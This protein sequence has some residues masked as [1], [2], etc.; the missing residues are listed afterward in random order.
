VRPQLDIATHQLQEDNDVVPSDII[1]AV[2]VEGD[3]P[4]EATNSEG[5]EPYEFTNTCAALLLTVVIYLEDVRACMGFNG[6]T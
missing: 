3:G 2:G 6:A 4:I 5:G 1:I